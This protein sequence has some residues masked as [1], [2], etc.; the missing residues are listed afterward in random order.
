MNEKSPAGD[1]IDHAEIARFE[2][3]ADAWWSPEGKFKALHALTPARMRFIAQ[4]ANLH[5]PPEPPQALALEN[6]RALDVGCGGGLASEPL[7]RMGATVTAV[8]PGADNIAAAKR[9]AESARL[10]IDYRACRAED[11]ANAGET[12]DLVVC[13][14]VVEHV[15]DPGALVKTCA[16][17]LAPGGL[18]IMST[19]NRTQRAYA[20]AIVGAEY[21]L[22]WLDRGTHQWDRFIKPDELASFMRAAGLIPG[23][24][25]GTVYAPMTDTWELSRDAGVN[26]M[27]AAVKPAQAN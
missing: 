23:A 19:I 16:A 3:L 5:R 7:A 25:R 12:F 14:E 15:P 9:H 4:A 10:A 1:N 13:L 18:L 20:L 17:C 11:V 8:D 22:G 21:I 6:W 27:M 24:P 2:K 26:Y